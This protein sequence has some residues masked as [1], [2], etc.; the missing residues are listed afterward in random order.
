MDA[1]EALFPGELEKM[2]RDAVAPYRDETLQDQMTEAGQEAD[3]QA[4]QEWEEATAE[5]QAELEQIAEAAQ[6]IYRKYE[7]RLAKLNAKLQAELAPLKE[8]LDEDDWL[9]D[10]GRSY[11]E[12][13]EAYRRHKSGEA[14]ESES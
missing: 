1:L 4:R 3:D 14:K 5:E 8:R 12:Q 6:K 10:S 13:I 7:P 11:E 9:Y 2:V